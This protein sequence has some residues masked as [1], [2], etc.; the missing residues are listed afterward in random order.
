MQ[1]SARQRVRWLKYKR[2]PTLMEGFL[3]REGPVWSCG[4]AEA[5]PFAAKRLFQSGSTGALLSQ[6]QHVQKEGADGGTRLLPCPWRDAESTKWFLKAT[7][8]RTNVCQDNTV[9]PRQKLL[10]SRMCGML[11]RVMKC[12]HLPLAPMA[13]TVPNPSEWPLLRAPERASSQPGSSRVSKTSCCFLAAESSGKGCDVPGRGLRA[14]Q[15]PPAP[16]PAAGSPSHP[17]G[18]RAGKH[19][20]RRA[21]P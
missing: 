10:P 7:S 21:Q 15:L 14:A 6:T 19:S 8:T 1:S 17:S 12:P 4:R 13:T 18:G 20:T 9:L 5:L 11:Q 16:H 2:K 3:G